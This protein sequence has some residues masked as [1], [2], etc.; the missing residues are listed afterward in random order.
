MSKSL[1]LRSTESI[2]TAPAGP[3]SI[4]HCEFLATGLKLDPDM[5]Y[6]NWEGIGRYLQVMSRSVQWWIGDWLVFGEHVFGHKY[7]QAIDLTG[8]DEQTLKNYHFVAAAIEQ[9]RRRDSLTFT[10]HAEVAGLPPKIQDE[11]L[12]LAVSEK[13]R[14]S[15]LRKHAQYRKAEIELRSKQHN[16]DAE[17]V[18]ILAKWRPVKPE[19]EEIRD[20]HPLVWAYCDSIIKE[21]DFF[22]AKP[23]EGLNDWVQV[24]VDSGIWDL[25]ELT[26]L[27]RFD[28]ATIEVI[29]DQLVASG[30]YERT[31][32]ETTDGARGAKRKML[33][34]VL[35]ERKRAE[36][37]GIADDGEEEDL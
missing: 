18:A 11:L 27:S 9:S 14:A 16:L 15:H 29:A 10:H 25:E 5:S 12:E 6:Q 23:L 36:I 21:M 34:P 7:A 20:A 13:L 30:N 19:L 22:L 8:K 1:S 37:L 31:E 4:P 35:V 17:V 3:F 24:Q 33:R 2:D 28:R 32:Q 26:K